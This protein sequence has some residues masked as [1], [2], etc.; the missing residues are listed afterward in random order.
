MSSRRHEAQ[1]AISRELAIHRN[2]IE[3]AQQAGHIGQ[4]P[5]REEIA[6]LKADPPAWLDNYLRPNL[7]EYRGDWERV[8]A[9][10]GDDFLDRYRSPR[11]L[12]NKRRQQRD[13]AEYDRKHGAQERDEEEQWFLLKAVGIPQDDPQPWEDHLEPE[14]QEFLRRRGWTDPTRGE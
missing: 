8:R 3:E 1:R 11:A 9:A 13:T 12:R 6:A 4:N 10:Y 7:K 5:S 2:Q 14:A